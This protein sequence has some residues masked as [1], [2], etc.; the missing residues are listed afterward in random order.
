MPRTIRLAA[1]LAF[2]SL[3]LRSGAVLGQQRP[4]PFIISADSARPPY[5]AIWLPA[6]WRFS[7]ADT[8]NL[9]DPEL[10]DSR[11]PL[12]EAALRPGTPLPEGWEGRGWFRLHLGVDS[13]LTH[14]AL[15]MRVQQLG[16]CEVYLDGRLLF[17]VGRVGTAGTETEGRLDRDYHVVE[18][19]GRPEHLL[20]V[21]YAN[22]QAEDFRATGNLGGFNL[23][24]YR[25][26]NTVFAGRAQEIRRRTGFGMLFTG[27]IAAF[28][29]LHLVLW[30]FSPASVEHLLFGLMIASFASIG[31]LSQELLFGTDPFVYLIGGPL[32][33]S[34]G[35]LIG[36]LLILF[37]YSVFYDHFPRLWIL[38]ACA[39]LGSVLFSWTRMGGP[40]S[41][42]FSAIVVG[43]IEVL[44]VVAV[45]FTRRKHAAWTVGLGMVAL[46][47]P[48]LTLFAVELGLIPSYPGIE[49]LPWF[50]VLGL[51]GG[52]SIYLSRSVARTSRALSAQVSRVEELSEQRVEQERR[53]RLEALERQR[54]EAEYQQRLFELE[55]ARKLQL[56]MLP[57]QLPEHPEVE[58]AAAM[59]TAQQVGGD[60]YDVRVDG[61]GT[62]TLAVGDATGHGLRAGTMVTATKSLFNALNREESLLH[63]LRQTTRALKGMNMKRLYM[64]L[65]LARYRRGRLQITAAGMPPAIVY[66]VASRTV[67]LIR[68]TGMPLGSFENF[69][70]RE[71]EV[72]LAPGDTV[73]FMSD[74]FPEV[75]N[76]EGEMLGYDRA[77]EIYASVAEWTPDDIV[78][79]LTEVGRRWA[80]G[81]A[82]NDDITF[83]VL[84]RRF[85][86]EPKDGA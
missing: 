31:W 16:A 37:V 21:R 39:A 78:G 85:E 18:L 68:L 40:T 81:R 35:V 42:G 32:G 55:E 36:L 83:F 86:I 23:T 10:D 11:W 41:I 52:M 13:T 84:R 48:M 27:V 6:E 64:A 30:A 26:I 53:L 49:N 74:G 54:L 1:I 14:R 43:S 20:A 77:Q 9:A 56:S 3:P 15:A 62:L 51:T 28:A 79:H 12:V 72:D 67:E 50:G 22:P 66:R 44:R 61:D 46:A 19:D 5:G 80:D 65:T 60:Y 38:F 17:S 7:S 71:A 8:P 75:F 45:A 69:P 76:E 63:I 4:A 25:E 57:G 73:L 58:L 24:V 2:G 59:I 33:D 70:Y 29:L 82:L 47:V 34:L